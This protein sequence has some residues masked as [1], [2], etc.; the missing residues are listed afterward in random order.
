VN[1]TLIL[2]VAIPFALASYIPLFTSAFSTSLVQKLRDREAETRSRLIFGAIS[3]LRDLQVRL[4]DFFAEWDPESDPYFIK[5]RPRDLKKPVADYLRFMALQ[6][7]M[8]RALDIVAKLARIA[9]WFLVAFAA[10]MTAAV[11]LGILVKQI[12]TS[13]AIW[14]LIAA[15]AVF[16]AGGVLY[17]V[18][19]L[20]ARRVDKAHSVAMELE[21][22]TVLG[23]EI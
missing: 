1:Q 6:D 16:L 4:E 13:W 10:L 18:I 7:K 9:F 5:A 23:D 19:L 12:G 2:S 14:A 15:G 8:K 21:P 20:Q 17:L 3:Q 11:I 22:D